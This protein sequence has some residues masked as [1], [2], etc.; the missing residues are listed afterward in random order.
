MTLAD[1]ILSFQGNLKLDIK[2]PKD[3]LVMNPYVDESTRLICKKFYK[4]FYNDNLERRVILGINPGRHGGGITGIPFTDPIKLESLGI[5]NDYQKRRELS[6]DFVYQVIEAFGGAKKFYQKFYIGAVSPLGFTKEDKNLNYYDA[7]GL[8]E[9]LAEYIVKWLR[10]QL[11]WGLN[12]QVCFC[13]GEGE[14]FKFLRKINERHRFFE[15]IAP[16]PHPRFIMQYRRKRVTEY[17]D[18]YLRKFATGYTVD[19]R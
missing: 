6:A 15:K 2:L 7:K 19:H 5:P 12:R 13:L 16:L 1:R 17:V 10:D 8:P 9:L 4:R 14:N 11:D 18:L 3:V